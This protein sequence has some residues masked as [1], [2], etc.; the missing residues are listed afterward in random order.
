MIYE[1]KSGLNTTRGINSPSNED[2]DE[3]ED[4]KTPGPWHSYT[5]KEFIEL[6]DNEEP[7]VTPFSLKNKIQKVVA[8]PPNDTEVEDP[9]IEKRLRGKVNKKDGTL[10]SASDKVSW[11]WWEQRSLLTYKTDA[12][13]LHRHRCWPYPVCW[14]IKDY[15]PLMNRIQTQGSLFFTGKPSD[16]GRGLWGQKTAK[17]TAWGSK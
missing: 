16:R 13:S 6:S 12:I 17:K 4:D 9:D 7:Y 5:S 10:K 8:P 1:D 15:L 2:R 11:L 14:F 3:V